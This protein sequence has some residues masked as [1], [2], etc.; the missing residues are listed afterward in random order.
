MAESFNIHRLGN[1]LTHITMMSRSVHN[2][3]KYG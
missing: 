2:S 3:F 1:K